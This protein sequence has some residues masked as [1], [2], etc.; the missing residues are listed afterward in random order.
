AGAAY[1]PL[2]PAYPADRLQFIAADAETR[3]VVTSGERAALYG[4][5]ALLVDDPS[6]ASEPADN[7]VSTARPEDPAY[8]IYTSG[9]TGRPKGV[10][11]THGNVTT[12]FD[13]MQPVYGFGAAD[14]WPWFHS[15]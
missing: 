8:V 1:V 11:V 9:S 4:E 6:I 5:R 13:C 15:A 10:I 7:V 2:D 14:V 12:L 3:L